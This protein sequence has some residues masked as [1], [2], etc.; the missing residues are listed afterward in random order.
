VRGADRPT[1]KSQPPQAKAP[2]DRDFARACHDGPDAI[3]RRTAA[4]F[5]FAAA[6]SLTNCKGLVREMGGRA[7]RGVGVVAGCIALAV[8][9]SGCDP[10]TDRRYVNEGAGVDL[11]T[12][13]RAGQT[14]LLKEY[15]RF[16]CAQLGPSCTS[17][18]GTFVL[19]GMNDIDQRCDGFLTWLDARRRDKEPILAEISAINT[20]AHTIMTVTGSN[21]A[22][23]DIVTAAFGLASASYAN[24]NSRLLISANQSTVQEI[25]Y[26]GQGDFR[27]KIKTYVVPDQPTA[28][29]LLRNYLRLCMPIT[30]EASI[31]T[32]TTLVLRDAPLAARKNLVVSTVG[33]GRPAII[34]DVNTELKPFNPPRPPLR[35]SLSRQETDMT[36]PDMRLVLN[37]LCRPKAESDLGPAGSD[38][39]KTL[40]K[41]LADNGRTPVEILD[42]NAFIAIQELSEAKKRAC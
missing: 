35:V 42:R 2:P 30:I 18:W 28:I 19:A 41:F 38:A 37:T 33:P 21:P 15:E 36:S 24:W 10:V 34:R 13:D 29:Y 23:L 7:M 6:F 25:V 17:D 26:K 31:N 16:V 40:A 5:A 39:R 12:A 1:S 20:A 11:Y 3:V 14:E 22:S 9:V 27:E 8:L 4:F 32:T